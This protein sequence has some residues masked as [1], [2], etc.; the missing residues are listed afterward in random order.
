MVTNFRS[1][2]SIRPINYLIAEREEYKILCLVG[3]INSARL[4]VIALANIFGTVQN[5]FFRLYGI[6]VEMDNVKRTILVVCSRNMAN[7][8][9][10]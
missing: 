1:L 10:F 7:L 5:N 8:K 6:T 3:D 2:C 4:A 9:K